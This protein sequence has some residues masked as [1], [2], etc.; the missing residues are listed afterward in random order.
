M[1][2]YAVARRWHWSWVRQGK[3]A[4][5]GT[6]RRDG[7]E[8]DSSLYAIELADLLTGLMSQCPAVPLSRAVSRAKSF[9]GISLVVP[10]LKAA[11]P[12]ALSKRGCRAF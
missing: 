3:L 10:R 6:I 5:S 4:A 7:Y 8:P 9:G 2:A 1:N 11:I 12:R